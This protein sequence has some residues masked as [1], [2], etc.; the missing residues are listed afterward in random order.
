MTQRK[1]LKTSSTVLARFMNT[2]C[3]ID[4]PL[5]YTQHL[6]NITEIIPEW[7]QNAK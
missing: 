3:H 5:K 4:T 1:V 7:L 6:P 2:F